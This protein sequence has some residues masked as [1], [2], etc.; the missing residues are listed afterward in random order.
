MIGIAAGDELAIAYPA[1]DA[2][3]GFGILIFGGPAVFL[4]AQFL[5]LQATLGH[6][7]HS[8]LLALAELTILAVATAPLTLI[9]GIAASS[10]VLVAVDV[11]FSPRNRI[12]SPTTRGRGARRG[13]KPQGGRS[14]YEF[15]AAPSGGLRRVASGLR[16]RR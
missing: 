2:T 1:E 11:A 6:L 3:L 15:R 4:L 5:F 10:A 13:I 12:R 16:Q 8:R 7:P 14:D 9:A